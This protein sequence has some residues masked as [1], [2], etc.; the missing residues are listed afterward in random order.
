MSGISSLGVGSSVLTQDVLDQL[1]EADEAQFLRPVETSIE[2][3]KGKQEELESLSKKIKDLYNGAND[4]R[5]ITLYNERSSSV[6]GSSVEVSAGYGADI[7]NIDISVTQLATKHMLESGSF[8]SKSD[9]IATA[10]GTLSIDINGKNIEI[11]YDAGATLDDLK[12]RIND[13]ASSDLQATIMQV[14]DGDFRLFLTSKETGS[15]QNITLSD[16]GGL[17]GGALNNLTAGSTIR[18]G[19]DALFN[20]NGIDMTRSSNDVNDVLPNLTFSLK[21]VGDSSV[22][23]TQDRGAI[24]DK[25]EEFVTNYNQAMA[26]LDVL[27]KSSMTTDERGIFSSEST[28][29]SLRRTMQDLFDT[30]GGGVADMQQ[31]GF[32]FKDGSLSFDRSV[33]DGKMSEN[34]S[35]VKAFLS[36][37]TFTLKDGTTTELNGMFG[38]ITNTLKEYGARNGVLDSYKTSLTDELDMLNDRKNANIKRLDVRYEILKKQFA[39]YDIMMARY[40]STSN[41]ISQMIM[42]DNG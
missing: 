38:D 31:F 10:G 8:A 39:A 34:M 19:K 20:V 40:S 23:I 14:G 3:A 42:A 13:L 15:G 11:D 5:D 7:Q 33:L 4:L 25:I 30:F 36:G 24:L 21:A 28:I 17:D 41:M 2:A 22:S 35:N 32:E 1:R 16:S 6:S 12:N 37:G 29:K 18:A 26:D 27:T 9:A